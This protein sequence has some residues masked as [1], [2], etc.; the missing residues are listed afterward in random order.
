[1][2]EKQTRAPLRSGFVLRIRFVGPAL[3][4]GRSLGWVVFIPWLV[5]IDGRVN[6]LDE[7]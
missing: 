2:N 5:L 3:C 7:A 4:R 1:M 6:H